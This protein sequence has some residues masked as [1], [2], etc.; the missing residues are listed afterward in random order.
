MSNYFYFS[1]QLQCYSAQHELHNSHGKKKRKKKTGYHIQYFEK[2][3]QE[4]A[5]QF[6]LKTEL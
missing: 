5:E 1:L 4:G 2:V 6:K 3:K